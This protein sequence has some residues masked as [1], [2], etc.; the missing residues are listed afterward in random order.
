MILHMKIRATTVR[1]CAH[2]DGCFPVRGRVAVRSHTLSPSFLIMHRVALLSKLDDDVEPLMTNPGRSRHRDSAIAACTG[3]CESACACLI[4]S[5]FA[6]YTCHY[7]AFTDG[8]IT[9]PP[10][11]VLELPAEHVLSDSSDEDSPPDDDPADPS[12]PDDKAQPLPSELIPKNMGGRR[13]LHEPEWSKKVWSFEPS[14]D[15]PSASKWT[16]SQLYSDLF[17]HA[18]LAN[19]TDSASRG[20]VAVM[21]KHMPM[22]ADMPSWDQAKVMLLRRSPMRAKHYVTCPR[23]TP[24]FV[25]KK[26]LEEMDATETAELLLAKCPNQLCDLPL[27]N[28]KSASAKKKFIRVRHEPRAGH[29]TLRT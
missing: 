8:S 1:H 6:L 24:C 22:F 10:L 11:D 2:Y 25:H 13:L 18:D 12:L 28:A 9:F 7:R 16:L 19:A 20:V 21:K 29:G 17:L 3:G 14:I 5:R 23:P 27:A 15:A 26:P 4:A